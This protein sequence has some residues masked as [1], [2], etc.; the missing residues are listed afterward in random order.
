MYW[1]QFIPTLCTHVQ[2]VDM[3]ITVLIC[4][5]KKYSI[6]VKKKKKNVFE[7]T[8]TGD[9]FLFVNQTGV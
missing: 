5:Y 4:T 8:Q 7:S 3:Y 1:L 2:T 9:N 6:L